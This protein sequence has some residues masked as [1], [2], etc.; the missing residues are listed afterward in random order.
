M[1]ELEGSCSICLENEGKKVLLSCGHGFHAACLKQVRDPK[2]PNCRAPIVADADGLDEEDVRM[3]KKRKQDD[4]VN[5]NLRTAVAMGII[6]RIPFFRRDILVQMLQR[7]PIPIILSYQTPELFSE[8]YH[9]WAHPLLQQNDEAFTCTMLEQFASNIFTCLYGSVD[10]IALQPVPALL[11]FMQA[12]SIAELTEDLH[13]LSHV[14]FP[15]VD[16]KTLKY[17]A[18]SAYRILLGTSLLVSA[19]S[20]E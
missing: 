15:T 12:L 18:R 4:H 6:Q 2:C 16:C 1:E 9:D 20:R 7:F 17:Y 10:C 8:A 13:G 5:D 3:M 14:L 11:F 19:L